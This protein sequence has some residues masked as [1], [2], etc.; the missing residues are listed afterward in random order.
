MSKPTYDTGVNGH[1]RLRVGTDASVA[2][3]CQHESPDGLSPHCWACN[4]MGAVRYYAP[5][6]MHPDACT[7]HPVVDDDSRNRALLTFHTFEGGP[8]HNR[9]CELCGLPL[10]VLQH[11]YRVPA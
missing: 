5:C 10:Q 8:P 2:T 1:V 6:D 9:P 4:P 7:G 3:C 11:V